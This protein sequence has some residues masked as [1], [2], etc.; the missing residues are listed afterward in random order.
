MVGPGE[1]LVRLT[2]GDQVLSTTLI[3]ERDE[4]GYLG[5]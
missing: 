1:Y 4:P 5:R 3:I 2:A